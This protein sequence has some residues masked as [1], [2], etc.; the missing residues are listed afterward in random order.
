MVQRTAKR[1]ADLRKLMNRSKSKFQAA[2]R[3]QADLQ[4]QIQQVAHHRHSCCC[5]EY[6]V[7]A[8]EAQ[9]AS[10][11]VWL[12]ADMVCAHMHASECSL[13]PRHAIRLHVVKGNCS[14]LLFTVLAPRHFECHVCFLVAAC[15]KRSQVC[16]D[17]VLLMICWCSR[18]VC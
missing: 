6:H 5:T 10:C 18:G 3:K 14:A 15:F 2:Q 13:C 8:E 17:M 11:P 12:A 7:L 9:S 1:A 16:Q 4:H